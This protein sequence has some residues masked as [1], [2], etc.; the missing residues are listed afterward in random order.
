M[1][2]PA[3]PDRRTLTGDG[4]ALCLRIRPEGRRLNQTWSAVPWPGVQADTDAEVMACHHVNHPR[5]LAV[6]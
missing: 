3:G 2:R 4:A 6:I 1:R 5:K